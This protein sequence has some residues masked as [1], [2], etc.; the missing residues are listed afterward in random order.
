VL[1]YDEFSRA[2][3]Q[4][5]RTWELYTSL[6]EGDKRRLPI[7]SIVLDKLIEARRYREALLSVPLT[8]ILSDFQR[9]EVRLKDSTPDE[10]KQFVANW[11]R[12]A[13]YL[14][15]SGKTAEAQ[16]FIRKALELNSDS[17]IQARIKAILL[18]A[19][20]PDLMGPDLR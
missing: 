11:M 18:R 14:A 5:H 20:Q 15:G 13:E 4:D 9:A 2:L 10:R 3:K 16:F 6:P 8:K 19:G 12:S 1:E 17:D 7:G